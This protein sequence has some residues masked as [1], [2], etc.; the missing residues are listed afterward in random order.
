MDTLVSATSQLRL[1]EDG[2]TAAE[3]VGNIPLDPAAVF[4]YLLLVVTFGAIFWV[5]RSR[6]QPT[7]GSPS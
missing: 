6:K 4:T 2:L 7:P 1:D 5:G 3:I